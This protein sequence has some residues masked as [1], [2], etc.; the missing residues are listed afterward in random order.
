[1]VKQANLKANDKVF[2]FYRNLNNE[3]F[4]LL[5]TLSAEI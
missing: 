2:R 5:V 1:M 4:L 3:K